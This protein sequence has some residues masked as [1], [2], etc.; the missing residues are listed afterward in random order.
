M[1]PLPTRL[2]RR[3]T[4]PAEL[5]CRRAIE[6]AQVAGLSSSD[7]LNSVDPVAMPSRNLPTHAAGDPKGSAQ[8]ITAGGSATRPVMHPMLNRPSASSDS[9]SQR[10]RSA[11]FSTAARPAAL[12]VY[13]SRAAKTWRRSCDGFGTTKGR[14]SS[15]RVVVVSAAMAGAQGLRLW[16]CPTAS[17]QATSKTITCIEAVGTS[18]RRWPGWSQPS[19]RSGDY[20]PGVV[21]SPTV[22]VFRLSLP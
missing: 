13:R 19:F 2:R 20:P 5:L 16:G 22:N 11:R 14:E 15:T 9:S 12:H 18:S 10:R 3:S 7:P 6:K 4:G 17:G 21:R 1:R 8:R